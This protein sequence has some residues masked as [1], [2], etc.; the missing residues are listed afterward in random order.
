[1][2]FASLIYLRNMRAFEVKYRQVF[3]S[4]VD[5]IYKDLET[6]VLDI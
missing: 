2:A 4:L 5:Y 3:R 1:M 6:V